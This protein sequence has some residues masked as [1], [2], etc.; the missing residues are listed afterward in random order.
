MLNT[1]NKEVIQIYHVWH[2]FTPEQISK[3]S[4]KPSAV[5]LTVWSWSS[6]K[7]YLKIQFLPQ[8]KHNTPHYKDQLVNAV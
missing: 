2:F 4:S 6:S 1:I 5:L 7:Y 8:R 3:P